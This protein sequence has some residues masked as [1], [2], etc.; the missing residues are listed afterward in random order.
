M[1]PASCG[2]PST[3][4]PTAPEA[5]RLAGWAERELRDGSLAKAEA[6]VAA[7]LRIAPRHAHA[8]YVL[9]GVR[10]L[11]GDQPGALPLFRR[12]AR[13]S[14][15]HADAYFELGNALYAQQQ[16]PAAEAAY[17]DAL[18]AQPARPLCHTNLGN[19]YSEQRRPAEAERSYR[20]ALELSPAGWDGCVSSNG[21]TNLLDA[22]E[23]LAEARGQAA[24]MVPPPHRAPFHTV[25]C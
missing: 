2:T 18:R 11:S 9:G 16:L 13:L 22:A 4:A 3:F 1:P 12:A 14:P 8:Y 15:A 21:L 6:C 17:S 7:A 20:R 23:R 24:H 5:S 25:H 10:V 19:I